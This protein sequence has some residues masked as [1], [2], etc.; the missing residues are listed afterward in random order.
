M[1]DDFKN[2]PC[3]LCARVNAHKVL[4]TQDRSSEEGSGPVRLIGLGV[5]EPEVGDEVPGRTR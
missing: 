4:A 2:A 5:G 3:I 1:A